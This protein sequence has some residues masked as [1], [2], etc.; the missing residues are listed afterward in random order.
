MLLNIK[1]Q[2]SS[3]GLQRIIDIK[4]FMNKSLSEKLKLAFPNTLPVP[5]P[6]KDFGTIPLFCWLAGFVDGEGCFHVGIKK[7]NII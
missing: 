4:A 6:D 5:R 1:V 3:E 7:L 2:S